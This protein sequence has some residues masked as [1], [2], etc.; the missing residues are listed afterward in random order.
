MVGAPEFEIDG[1][2]PGG[3]AVPLLRDARWQLGT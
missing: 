3:R 2:E 1:V